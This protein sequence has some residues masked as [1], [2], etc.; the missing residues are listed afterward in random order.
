[1]TLAAG[2]K[3]VFSPILGEFWAPKQF[4]VQFPPGFRPQIGF[5][6]NPRRVWGSESVFGVIL[7]GFWASNWFLVQ[8]SPGL[9]PRVRVAGSE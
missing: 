8:S 7:G 2:S 6:P 9:G 5:W 3:S 1:M 4:L